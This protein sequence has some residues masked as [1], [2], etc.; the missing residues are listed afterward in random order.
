MSD[1][2]YRLLNPSTI[3]DA[4][5]ER[6]LCVLLLRR[7]GVDNYDHDRDI[8]PFV[9]DDHPDV[10]KEVV[11]QWRRWAHDTRAASA[12]SMLFRFAEHMPDGVDPV[13]VGSI[14]EYHKTRWNSLGDALH[15]SDMRIK[16]E[17]FFA[18]A[19][20]HML[21][22]GRVWHLVEPARLSGQHSTLACLYTPIPQDYEYG[23]GAQ[24]GAVC[25]TCSSSAFWLNGVCGWSSPLEYKDDGVQAWTFEEVVEG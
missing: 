14:A 4:E 18:T 23:Q 15:R 5:A 2:L 20:W 25:I 10:T 1:E 3:G 19:R 17:A 24:P 11:A 13:D 9:S 6:R 12:A 16:S 7:T 8:L 21:P 22:K